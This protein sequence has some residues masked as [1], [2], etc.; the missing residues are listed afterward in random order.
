MR[1]VKDLR[2]SVKM[3]Q[4]ELADRA[5]TSQPTIAAYEA[6]RKSPTLRTLTRLT[7][8]VVAMW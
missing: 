5:G 7:H 8:S 2:T 1:N 3:T 4:T 6:G